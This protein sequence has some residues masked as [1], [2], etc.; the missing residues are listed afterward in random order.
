VRRFPPAISNALI[1]AAAVSVGGLSRLEARPS[2]DSKDR[3]M[4]A[5]DLSKLRVLVVDDER[6]VVK[7]VK[8]MLGEMGIT[9][10]FT[11]KDGAEALV[12]LGDCENLVNLIICDWN[13]PNM[14]GIELLQQV[15]T[16]DPAMLFIML[17]GRTTAENVRDAK[18]LHVSAYI[19]KPFSQEQLKQKIDVLAKSVSDGPLMP[20]A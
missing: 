6:S 12:F 13:M 7:L 11:A 19:A 20:G 10:V 4:A 18:N 2:R 9:Q 16:A 15:R 5:S 17:T 14:S 8:M 1:A 3:S